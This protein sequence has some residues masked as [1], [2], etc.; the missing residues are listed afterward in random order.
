MGFVEGGGGGEP[1]HVT[2]CFDGE[3]IM[4][5]MLRNMKMNSKL[6]TPFPEGMGVLALR[7]PYLLG[8]CVFE[9]NEWASYSEKKLFEFMIKRSNDQDVNLLVFCP[10]KK[11]PVSGVLERFKEDMAENPGALIRLI[12]GGAVLTKE[13]A[14][15]DQV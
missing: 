2:R 1:V 12:E 10:F 15:D 6:Y 9:I 7:K 14:Y 13:R 5:H 11:M 3:T 8:I 4:D